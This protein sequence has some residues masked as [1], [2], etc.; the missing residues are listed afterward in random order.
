MAVQSAS[1]DAAS[2]KSQQGRIGRAS[3]GAG[4][5]ETPVPTVI[6]WMEEDFDDT[7]VILGA[8]RTPDPSLSLKDMSFRRF[9][10]PAEGAKRSVVK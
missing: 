5:G 4:T 6:V 10:F 3:T 1:A 2:E 9:I 8:A 7:P